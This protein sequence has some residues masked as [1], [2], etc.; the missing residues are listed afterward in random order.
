MFKAIWKV[1]KQ[2]IGIK[3]HCHAEVTVN[4][5]EDSTIKKENTTEIKSDKK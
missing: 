2:L 1:L 4:T 5:G 3:V